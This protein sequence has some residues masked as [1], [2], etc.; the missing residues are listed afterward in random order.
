MARPSRPPQRRAH[1]ELSVAMR[2]YL[3]G[4]NG[5]PASISEIKAAIEPKIGIAPASSYRS[6]LQNERYFE[7]V[8]RGVF[9]LRPG[10]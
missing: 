4:K 10:A 3:A 7:R 1:G 8:A 6:A 5:E 2:E 9:R